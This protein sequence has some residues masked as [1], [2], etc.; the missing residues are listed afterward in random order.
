M[1][2]AVLPLLTSIG[3]KA[4]RCG[5]S[6][7]PELVKRMTDTREARQNFD[8]SAMRGTV[9]WVPIKFHIVRTTACTGGANEAVLP[10]L[11]DRL[12]RDYAPANVQFFQCGVPEIICNDTYYDMQLST[13]EAPLCNTHDVPNVLNMYFFN[14][15]GQFAP[16]GLDGTAYFPGG[17]NRVH[18]MAAAATNGELLAHE[19]GHFFGL[20]HTHQSWNDPVSG[21]CVSGANC[22]TA[23]DEVCDTP[24]EPNYFSMPGL[25]TSCTYTGTILDVCSA[26]YVSPDVGNFMN[27]APYFCQDHFTSGQYNRIG[28][29]AFVDRA[30]LAC[31]PDIDRPCGSPVTA[32]PYFQNFDVA[33]IGDWWNSTRDNFNWF[34]TAVGPQA[35]ATGPTAPGD[36]PKF[37]YIEATGN[38]PNK[39]AVLESP[40]FDLTKTQRPELSFLYHMTGANIGTLSLEAT[41]NGGASWF[42][43]HTRTGAQAA[44]WLNQKIDLSQYVSHTFFKVRFCASTTLADLGDIAIDDFKIYSNPCSGTG[45]TTIT[46]TDLACNYVHSGEAKVVGAPVGSTYQWSTG[47]ATSTIIGTSAVLTGLQPGP[48]QVSV[49][50]AGCVTTLG[51][52]VEDKS[53]RITLSPTHPTTVG[54]TGSIK[55]NMVDGTSPY[56]VVIWEGPVSGSAAPSGSVHNITGLPPGFY[57]VKV[58]DGSACY[59]GESV[60]IN[61]YTPPFCGCS[62]SVGVGYFESFEAGLGNWTV[63]TN[64]VNYFPWAIGTGDMAPVGTTGPTTATLPNVPKGAYV[65]NNYIYA[66]SASYVSPQTSALIASPC[67]NFTGVANPA[68]TFKWHRLGPN[69]NNLQVY[70]NK[71]GAGPPTLLATLSGVNADQWNTATVDLSLAGNTNGEYSL[72]FRALAPI[73]GTQG[74]I[75]ID[76]VEFINCTGSGPAVT[77]SFSNASCG[78]DGSATVTATCTAGVPTYAWS[79]GA[80][81]STVNGLAPGNYSCTVS[82]PSTTCTRIVFFTIAAQRM[83]PSTNVTHVLLAGQA[84][85][86]VD[87]VVT[88]GRAPYTY[89]WTGPGGFTASTQDISNLLA[90]TYAVTITDAVGCVVTTTALVRD[91]GCHSALVNANGYL[92]TFDANFGS[93]NNV[94]EPA[95][96]TDWTWTNLASAGTNSGPTTGSVTPG[97]VYTNSN[98]PGNASPKV[99]HLVSNCIDLRRASSATFFFEYSQINNSPSSA[100][101]MGDLA[102]DISTDQGQ[103]WV[104]SGFTSTGLTATTWVTGNVSLAAYVGKVIKLRFTVAMGSQNRSDVGLDNL[105]ITGTFFREQPE[106]ATSLTGIVLYPNPTSDALFVNYSNELGVPI[107]CRI[108]DLSG[109]VLSTWEQE[110]QPGA[111]QLEVDTRTLSSGLYLLEMEAAGEKNVKRFS[112]IR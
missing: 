74:D 81:T 73:A 53:F 23:G 34:V 71:Q 22:A 42:V 55:V 98:P 1:A 21:E 19:V 40:C 61:T 2:A 15:L 67:L 109:Q 47:Y 64:P 45:S 111:Q 85:G 20:Y 78:N 63:C 49:T 95:N 36:G 14:Q 99:A 10:G 35:P 105:R 6:P 43:L 51:A 52:F 84:N 38:T 65:G 75:A 29:G 93:W 32:F 68:V 79:N 97:Y 101:T 31:V 25:L 107:Q 41:T 90:G 8:V 87:L 80:T 104:A 60:T 76:A 33:G 86:A 12:N 27:Y 69:V 96:G 72:M 4:Q 66:V 59:A 91:G 77:T 7:D 54:G 9:K 13:E 62:G 30:S 110:G 70:L 83:I 16:T 44:G 11:L 46:H 18:I 3:L 37:A 100:A 58:K 103:T 102:L 56:S 106:V 57:Q 50:Y 24:A 89:S 94:V 39:V 5:F 112:V 82:C 26:P 88:G 92:E 17:P 28:Y 108:L 48:Y